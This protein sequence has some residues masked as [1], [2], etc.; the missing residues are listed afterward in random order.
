MGRAN[1]RRQQAVAQQEAEITPTVS[2]ELVSS[3]GSVLSKASKT[4]LLLVGSL[5]SLWLA[6][7]R[8]LL[9]VVRQ[10]FSYAAQIVQGSQV[11]VTGLT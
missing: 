6:Q 10:A 8:C 2:L 7:I 3:V 4:R 5:T 11:L 1:Q 9:R